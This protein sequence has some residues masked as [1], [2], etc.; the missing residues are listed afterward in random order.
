MKVLGLLM[1]NGENDVLPEMIGHYEAIVDAFYVLDG[2]LPNDTSKALC[3]GSAKCGGYITDAE[4][5][6]DRYPN[7]PVCGYRQA[8]YEQA[9]ADHGHNNWFVLLHGDEVW[10]T[11]PA[12]VV[13]G[14]DGYW[15]TLPF[16]FPRAGEPWDYN[17]HPLDQL[18]WNL[19]PGWPEFRMFRGSPYVK[20]WEQQTFNA[21]PDGVVGG[22]RC[23]APIK[24]YLYRSPDAQRERAKQH[25]V[26][27]FDPDNYKHI[28]ERDAVYWTDEMIAEYQQREWFRTLSDD[29]EETTGH[30][31]RL[32]RLPRDEQQT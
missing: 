15:F 6:R 10:T 17:Q 2:T 11:Y 13:N 24:H 30:D 5:P 9:V 4:L 1:I 27:G 29:R 23:A 25:L 28:T 12:D 22:G 20:Y 21:K 32:R 19:S 8:I 14:H 16:Y 26:T 31:V 3:T 18:H 7:K